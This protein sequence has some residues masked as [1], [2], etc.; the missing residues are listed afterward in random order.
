MSV[1]ECLGSVPA[2]PGALCRGDWELFDATIGSRGGDREQL[3]AARDAA[4][5]LCQRCPALS[6]CGSWFDSLP[7]A[8]RPS[9]ITAGRLGGVE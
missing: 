9:A 1:W 7:K 8:A 6:P 3:Q 2:L 5:A 4:V